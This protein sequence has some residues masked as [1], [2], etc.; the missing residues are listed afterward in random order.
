MGIYIKDLRKN[1]S[2]KKLGSFVILKEINLDINNGSILA[3]IGKNGAGKT[4]LLNIIAG[5]LTYDSGSINYNS[6]NSN[7]IAIVSSNDRSFFWNLTVEQ[8]L[9]FFTPKFSEDEKNNTLLEI[10]DLKEKLSYKY[11]DLSSGEKKKAIICRSIISGAKVLI[12]DEF[13]NSL[14]HATKNATYKLIKDLIKNNILK[15]VIFVTHDINEVCSLATRCIL[16]SDGSIS[17]DIKVNEEIS[18]IDIKNLMEC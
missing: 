13:T 12:F 2:N 17:K 18:H 8:N 14:D 9:N 4:T 5:R 7:S 16:I 15:I 10:F 11:S 1:F 6:Y 3:I